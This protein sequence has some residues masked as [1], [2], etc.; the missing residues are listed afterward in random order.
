M[1]FRSKGLGQ[2]RTADKY[3]KELKTFNEAKVARDKSFANGM[4]KVLNTTTDVYTNFEKDANAAKTLSKTEVARWLVNNPK[5]YTGEL[6]KAV[7][8]L[9]ADMQNTGKFLDGYIIM[10]EVP[11]ANRIS[12]G[13]SGTDEFFVTLVGK[14]KPKLLD[15][16]DN[17]AQAPAK[18][19]QAEAAKRAMLFDAIDT[20]V[21]NFKNAPEVR[22]IL[23]EVS[24]GI[25]A[26]TIDAGGPVGALY[27]TEGAQSLGEIIGKV[28]AYKNPEAMGMLSDMIEKIW[29]V[30][31][32]SNIRSIYGARGGIAITKAR[33]FLAANQAEIGNA[34]AEIA[35][36]SDLGP[37]ISKL[38]SSIQTKDAA[39][40]KAKKKL[41]AAQKT[42]VETEK[43]GRAH[44]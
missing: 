24:R 26:E 25:K 17:F 42:A 21:S 28:A 10:D 44:V 19:K 37:N 11:Q 12:V 5:T 32:Y 8:T 23:D 22:Q 27:F 13:A 39:L 7:D 15:L 3:L 41:D 29:K 18:V 35:N 31:G 14:S 4:Q 9:S 20:E 33:K 34:A 36:P 38:L 43:I 2:T 16:A 1:L 40:A 30:D 6:T